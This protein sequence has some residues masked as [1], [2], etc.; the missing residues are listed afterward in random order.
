MTETNTRKILDDRINVLDRNAVDAS[1][2]Q[3]VFK[4]VSAI[5]VLTRVSVLFLVPPIYS[6]RRTNQDKMIDNEDSV[7]LSEY[8]FDV[9]TVLET[10]IQGKKNVGSLNKYVRMALGDLERCVSWS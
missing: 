4:T 10:A 6:H 5:L 2:A 3:R 8:C 1:P 9:C 7:Q